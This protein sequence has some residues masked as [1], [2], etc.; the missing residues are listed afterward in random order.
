[1]KIALGDL[2][3]DPRERERFL[4]VIPLLLAHGEEREILPAEEW[5]LLPGDRLLLCGRSLAR[6]RMGWTLQNVDS[7]NYVLTGGSSPEGALWQWFS[8]RRA[9]LERAGLDC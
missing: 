3:R 4:P 1:M 6:S 8:R 2:L 7:L 9:K 5:R